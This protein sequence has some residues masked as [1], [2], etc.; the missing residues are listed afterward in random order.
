MEPHTLWSTILTAGM[1]A[2]GW[3]AKT[4]YSAIR[5][6]EANLASHKVDVA[7][8]YAPNADVAR[9]EDKL[10]RILDKLDRKADK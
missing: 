3:I 4:F 6:L 5:E 7:R 2:L 10:D 8:T 1:A 9:L